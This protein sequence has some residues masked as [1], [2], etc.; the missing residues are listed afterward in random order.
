MLRAPI[1]LFGRKRLYHDYLLK[2]ASI[3]Q[4]KHQIRIGQVH[5]YQFTNRWL[6]ELEYI[7]SY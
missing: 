1:P 3:K 5:V 4:I 7:N 2:A 6:I